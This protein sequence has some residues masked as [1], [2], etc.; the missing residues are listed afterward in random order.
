MENTDDEIT[1]SKASISGDLLGF[2]V[3]EIVEAAREIPTGFMLAGIASEEGTRLRILGP[4]GN[5]LHP[6]S[7][8]KESDRFYALAVS[9]GDIR[10]PNAEVSDRRAHATEINQDANGGS[11]H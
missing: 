1:G 2:E 8:C 11:L 5:S 6:I 9:L 10:R 7:V 4:S 3:G